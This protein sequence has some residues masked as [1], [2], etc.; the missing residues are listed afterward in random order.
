[1]DVAISAGGRGHL[2]R[3]KASGS[4]TFEDRYGNVRILGTGSSAGRIGVKVQ[5]DRALS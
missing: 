5:W 3:S 2:D 4:K 1:M